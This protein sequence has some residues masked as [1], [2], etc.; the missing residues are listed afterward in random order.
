MAEIRA[1]TTKHTTHQ[2]RESTKRQRGEMHHA[3]LKAIRF[4]SCRATVYEVDEV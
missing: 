2:G 1:Q 3:E 4:N